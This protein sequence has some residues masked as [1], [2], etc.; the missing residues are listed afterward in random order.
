MIEQEIPYQEP[1]QLLNFLPTEN[2]CFLDSA[3]RHTELGRYSYIGVDPF[4]K[5]E[6]KQPQEK[7]LQTIKNFLDTFSQPKY[8][9]LPPFQG[10][11]IGYFAYE[12]GFL[13][14]PSIKT[15]EHAKQFP[16]CY[17]QLGCFDLVLSF[18]HIQKKA[19]I[20]STGF[21]EKIEK[22][23]LQRAKTRLEWLNKRI[24]KR[25]IVRQK[26]GVDIPVLQCDTS[27]KE[28][29]SKVKRIID[30]IKAGDI[31]EANLARCY[32]SQLVNPLDAI[33]L[34]Q[35]LRQKNPAPFSSL[36]NFSPCRILSSSPER[37]IQLS[38]RQVEARPI[39][40]TIHR[41]KN[42][43]EDEQLGVELCHSEKDRAENIMIVDLMRNDLS[44]VC[45]ADSVN[46][47]QLCQLESYKKVH[48]L[49]SVITGKLKPNQSAID[50]LKA[51]FPGGS[52]TGAPKIRAMEI[53]DEL[54]NSQR[55]P[56]C[57]CVGYI[58]FNGEM[59]TSITIRT[60]LLN[61]NQLRFHTGGAITLASDPEKEYQETQI[62]AEA[63]KDAIL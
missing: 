36:L 16:H 49:V 26:N 55:G 18:N 32:C 40:G 39:K 9:G 4:D 52:I 54:E 8:P 1:E 7:P 12:L 56:Y 35:T 30:Y 48:H 14:E 51:T 59:D 53:I 6:L 46:V 31:F 42:K 29:I 17:Y 11:L 61:D 10:G 28:Y 57:G 23:R 2:L 45:L 5:L 20:I 19:W 58:G 13:L 3:A 15:T 37:F 22:K 50:L 25:A 24:E 27:H 43:L 33:E 47:P 60:L 63:L 62:K 34:Y 41:S 38:D 44:K 21:P